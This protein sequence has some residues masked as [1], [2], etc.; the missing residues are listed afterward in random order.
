MLPYIFHNSYRSV[1]R[2]DSSLRVRAE[3]L[4]VVVRSIVTVG[5]LAYDARASKGS[6][7]L[8]LLAFAL[9]QLAYSLALLAVYWKKYGVL[10][11]L[12]IKRPKS[13]R[14]ESHEKR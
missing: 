13:T 4:A 6:G 8:S 2:L 5:T 10:T 9:G 7:T 14:N 11:N 1:Q 3:G 12:T